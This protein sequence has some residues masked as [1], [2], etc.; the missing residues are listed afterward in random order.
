MTE[1]RNVS[2]ENGDGQ[3]PT[4]KAYAFEWGEDGEFYNGQAFEDEIIIQ[5]TDDQRRQVI[6]MLREPDDDLGEVGR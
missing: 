2:D 4:R 6:E 3:E 5:M 1:S